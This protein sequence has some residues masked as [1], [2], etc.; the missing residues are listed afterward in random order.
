VVELEGP[1]THGVTNRRRR[2][3]A[4]LSGIAVLFFS[5][6]VAAQSADTILGTR[7]LAHPVLWPPFHDTLRLDLHR[8]GQ[9][10]VAVWPAATQM[11]VAPAGHPDRP[12]FAARTRVGGEFTPTTFDLYAQDDGQHLFVLTPAPGTVR[13]R[14]WVWE[15][16]LAEGA[17]RQRHERTAGLGLSVEAGSVSGYAIE[18]PMRAPSSSYI[19]AGVVIGSNWFLS[20]LLGAGND[21]RA[22]GLISVNWAFAELRARLLNIMVVGR[23]LSLVA[24]ARVSQ[25]NAVTT[26]AD[27]AALG[28]GA[29]VTWHLDGRRG[30]RGLVIGAHASWYGLHNLALKSQTIHRIGVSVAW[31]P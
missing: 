3:A 12:A 28:G 22:Q 6:A 5:H 24:T 14:V 11:E 8:H 10:H 16:T 31:V 26:V 2:C 29:L 27:P 20:L 30:T 21:P 1:E 25:G 18:E 13:V 7:L 4:I 19:E 23:E 15:D 9:Y 17:I